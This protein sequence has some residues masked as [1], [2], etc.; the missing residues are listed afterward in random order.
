MSNLFRL[1]SCIIATVYHWVLFLVTPCCLLLNLQGCLYLCNVR[2]IHLRW[3]MIRKS[4]G[5][6][7]SYWQTDEA[8]VRV[9]AYQI[10]FSLKHL[11]LQGYKKHL[12][13]LLHFFIVN[14]KSLFTLKRLSKTIER[15]T[16]RHRLQLSTWELIDLGKL[17]L[18]ITGLSMTTRISLLKPLKQENMSY[19][20]L[21]YWIMCECNALFG[22]VHRVHLQLHKSIWR[23]MTGLFGYKSRSTRFLERNHDT[24][25]AGLGKII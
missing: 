1:C 8:E 25:Y 14:V 6:W 17:R 7:S 19:G 20:F 23:L 12:L 15:I 24:G 22:C 2:I 21:F 3:V 4:R 13:P 5:T 11:L 16:S 10:F 18:L 9:C